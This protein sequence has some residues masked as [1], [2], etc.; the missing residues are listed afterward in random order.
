MTTTSHAHLAPVTTSPGISITKLHSLWAPLQLCRCQTRSAA[1]PRICFPLPCNY[2]SLD[3]RLL[4]I[5]H[6]K[7]GDITYYGVARSL[8][9]LALLCEQ[10]RKATSTHV[11]TVRGSHSTSDKGPTHMNTAEARYKQIDC[12][13]PRSRRTA[14]LPPRNLGASDPPDCACGCVRGHSRGLVTATSSIW[15]LPA[16]TSTNGRPH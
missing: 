1:P 12:Q 10:L 13:R 8:Y 11:S 5:Q 15:V 6:G 7:Y 14:I 9:F 3:R 2:Y 4:Q 16:C